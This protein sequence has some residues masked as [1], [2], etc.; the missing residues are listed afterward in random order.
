MNWNTSHELVYHVYAFLAKYH[1]INIVGEPRHGNNLNVHQQMNGVRDVVYM[2]KDYCSATNKDK[3][4][5]SAV[6]R[7]ELVTLILSEVRQ[8]PYNLYLES[9]MWHK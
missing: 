4:M 8:I 2:H 7:M 1:F 9:S 3:I 6:T 5:P